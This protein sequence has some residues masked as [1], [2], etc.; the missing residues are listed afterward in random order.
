MS[1]GRGEE[2]IVEIEGKIVTETANAFLI[3]SNGRKEWVA[4]A[5]CQVDSDGMVQMPEWVALD[6]GFI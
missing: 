2:K 5:Q 1:Y 6:K 4:K 3:E